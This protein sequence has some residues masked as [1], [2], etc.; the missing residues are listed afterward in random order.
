MSVE[1]ISQKVRDGRDTI[2]GPAISNASELWDTAP[3]PLLRESLLNL[4]GSIAPL[5]LIAPRAQQVLEQS[6]TV[7]ISA[8][9]L[10]AETTT[11]TGNAAAQDMLE[12]AGLIAE[13]TAV[14][15]D[16]GH[17]MSAVVPELRA[18]LANLELKVR[19]LEEAQQHMA[20][21]DAVIASLQE[22]T[23]NDANTYLT[24]LGGSDASA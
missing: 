5:I 7:A 8:K 20:E 9:S 10:L 12:G 14:R 24:A 22:S 23:V 16:I 15:A 6:K 2:S 18:L 11:D 4:A 3:I 13:Q 17:R 21:T 19:E 1:D